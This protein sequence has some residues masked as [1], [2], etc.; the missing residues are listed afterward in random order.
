MKPA[1][2]VGHAVDIKQAEVRPALDA[3][4]NR[5]DVVS[6]LVDDLAH[7]IK[8]PLN[9]IV[10]NLEVLRRKIDAGATDVAL[11]RAAVIDEEVARVHLLVD[12]LLQLMRPVRAEPKAIALDDTLGELR[13]LLEVQAKAARVQVEM[14][15]NSGVFVKAS[16]D[17]LKFAVLN[18]VTAIYA[19]EGPLELIRIYTHDSADAEIV[20][21]SNT[22]VFTEANEF[23]QHA[24]AWIGAAGG[25]LVLMEP[26]VNGAGSTAILRMATCSSFA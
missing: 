12:Q 24:R 7:E 1:T 25:T 26:S 13:P 5:Y 8:N 17:V 3:R 22:T 18:L 21:G 2:A 16:R 4:A 10:V 19:A 23:V 9:A 6:R 11:E 20:V 14:D 15:L